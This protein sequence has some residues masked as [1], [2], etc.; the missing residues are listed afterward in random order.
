M[1]ASRPLL[2]LLVLLV[3]LSSL[4][5]HAQSCPPR[6][7]IVGV[8][9]AKGS[10]ITKLTI[11]NFKASHK[12]Q[13]LSISSVSSRAEPSV[14]T[15]VLLSEKASGKIA[16]SAA[17]EFISTAPPQALVSM[18]T[19]SATIERKFNSSGGRKPMEDWLNADRT[20]VSRKGLSN[21]SQSL[22]MIVKAM[23]PAHVGDA[24]YVITSNA[25]RLFFENLTK[26]ESATVAQLETELNSS[27]VRVFTLI[28]EA[29]P[30]LRWD[31]ILPDDNR[32]TT[33][34]SPTGTAAFAEL[35]RVSGGL[36]LDWYPGSKSVSF[37]PSFDY[38][39]A[40]RAAI[41]ESARGFQAVIDNFYVVTV[42]P[43]ERSSVPEEWKLEA[44]DSQG[45]KLKGATLAYPSK[46][47]G[48]SAAVPR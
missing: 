26:E 16:Q 15:V 6:P 20:D 14:R 40:M 2:L 11:E 1:L 30:S 4:A 9:D 5:V 8:L 41:R 27:G 19:F 36:G 24:I 18:F 34:H 39:N 13:P 29:I 47:P 23:E 28:L 43:P 17:L 35:I 37:G 25:D 33:P 38:D 22:L 45:K 12:G 3:A 32:I 21:L 48:C 7:V 10:P 44:V 31:V 42:T 46:I